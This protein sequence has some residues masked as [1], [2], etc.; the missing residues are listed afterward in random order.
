MSFS[1]TEPQIMARMKDVTRR[2][3]W[4]FLKPG[5]HVMACRKCMGL[6]PGEKIYR[7]VEIEIVTNRREPLCRLVD[8]PAYGLAEVIRE[9]FPEMTPADFVRFFLKSHKSLNIDDPISRVEFK[10]AA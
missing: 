3:G 10:Y 5:D 1:L 8:E 6:A 4:A 7:L 2:D 9:G